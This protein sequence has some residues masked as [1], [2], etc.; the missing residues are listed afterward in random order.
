VITCIIVLWAMFFVMVGSVT[1]VVGVIGRWAPVA[2]TG[3]AIL[4]LGTAPILVLLNRAQR[5]QPSADQLASSF[6]RT[7]PSPPL[8]GPGPGPGPQPAGGEGAFLAFPPDGKVVKVLFGEMVAVALMILALASGLLW[9][10]AGSA[11][12]GGFLTQPA[13]RALWALGFLALTSPLDL[14]VWSGWYVIRRGLAGIRLAADGIVLEDRACFRRPV[15]LPAATSPASDC[16][17]SPASRRASAKGPRSGPWTPDPT[18]TSS[19]AAPR[20]FPRRAGYGRLC[21]PT[22][23]RLLAHAGQ[24]GASTFASPTPMTSIA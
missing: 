20:R 14:V 10:P 1:L 15:Q 17:P 12:H 6:I 7:S 19:C 8:L 13:A 2:I 11:A 24:S 3:G 16:L 5:L 4:A 21:A 9:F 18:S 23:R 22:T